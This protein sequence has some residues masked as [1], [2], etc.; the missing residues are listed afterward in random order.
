MPGSKAEVMR[1]M[2]CS[3]F[4]KFMSKMVEIA[5]DQF[6]VQSIS[7][8]DFHLGSEGCN[9]SYLK[10]HHHENICTAIVVMMYKFDVP[11]DCMHNKF[12]T[13]FA[14]KSIKLFQMQSRL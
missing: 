5:F 9:V 4:L 8:Q 11:M 13:V 3:I 12:A 14:L 10:S 7:R 6:L 1:A 2:S